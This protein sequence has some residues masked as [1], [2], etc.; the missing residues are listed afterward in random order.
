MNNWSTLELLEKVWARSTYSTPIQEPA[1]V[2]IGTKRKASSTPDDN[3][4]ENH[5]Q[6][7]PEKDKKHGIDGLTYHGVLEEGKGGF[8]WR[9]VMDLGKSEGEYIVV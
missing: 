2:S 7:S 6:H 3:E 5:S 8:K 1:K 9:K 4:W